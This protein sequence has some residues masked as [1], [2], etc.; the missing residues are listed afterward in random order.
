MLET[1]CAVTEMV[2]EEYTD[3][4][5]AEDELFP[6]LPTE[7][8]NKKPKPS[9]EPPKP[10]AAKTMFGAKSKSGASTKPA[11]AAAGG[12]KAKKAPM[13]QGGIMGFFKKS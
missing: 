3:D 2:W 9:S 6:E 1:G 13:K 8:P 7:S 4:E 12:K 11:P 10:A 5:A